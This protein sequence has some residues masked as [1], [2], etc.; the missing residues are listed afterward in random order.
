MFVLVA[1]N[2]NS[3][4]AAVGVGFLP[5]S[6][7]DLYMCGGYGV[8]VKMLHIFG[9]NLWSL[10]TSLIKQLPQIEPVNTLIASNFPE[11]SAKP[12]K[13]TDVVA[14]NL[15]NSEIESHCTVDNDTNINDENA[16]NDNITTLTNT[17]NSINLTEINPSSYN[18]SDDIE[19]KP[20]PE[21]L[22][23]KSFLSALKKH[24]KSLQLPLLTSNFYRLYV[25][26]EFE[27]FFDIK[28]SSYKK[29]SNF[30][31]EMVQQNF[32]VIREESKGIDKIIS[33][34]L[35]HP[36]LVDFIAEY[37]TPGSSTIQ[38]QQENVSEQ[39]MTLFQS[40]MVEMYTITTETAP[41]FTVADYQLG[42]DVSLTEIKDALRKYIKQ[43]QL[44]LIQKR[45]SKNTSVKTAA[46][47]V[48]ASSANESTSQINCYELD[49][50][51]RKI[52]DIMPTSQ[53]YGEG[54]AIVA[55]FSSILGC[56]LDKMQVTYKMCNNVKKSGNDQKQ[57]KPPIKIW[58]STRRGN[59][60]VTLV[61]GM[62]LYG[63]I[64]S[65]F[66]K[67][68]KKGA[69]ANASVVTLPNEK[70]EVFQIQGNQVR[71]IHKLLTETCKIP[72]HS[73]TGLEFATK[74]KSS[75]KQK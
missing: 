16:N 43:R 42:Q 9:D 57:N 30:L 29:L 45:L 20:T 41:F 27:E 13:T 74:E 47:I 61:K 38:Q 21:M 14:E 75:S 44:K 67:L 15:T 3:N 34:D 49:P 35:K 32:I 1:V 7:D 8:A 56:I 18:N 64:L 72:G 48:A 5:R 28:K 24:G 54:E 59:K 10:E 33:I 73:I 26:P 66:V 70:S 50:V 36:E 17:L 19:E 53:N 31:N 22:L 37:R 62:E 4:L 63:I 65:E 6:S 23:K 39:S 25:V 51:L 40:E 68:C 69:A 46:S 2:L 71:F 52:C 11:L 58:L 55:Q 60:T 12:T